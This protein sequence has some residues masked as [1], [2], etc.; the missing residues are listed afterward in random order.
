MKRKFDKYWDNHDELN[1]L[2]FIAV[3]LDPRYKVKYLDFCFS[4]IYDKEK[5]KRFTKKVEDG[6]TRLFECY[7]EA[8]LA[9]SNYEA[10]NAPLVAD[11]EEYADDPRRLW[12]SNFREHLQVIE[13]KA[14]NTE[15]SRFLSELCE[16]DT[17]EFNIL[18]WW[19]GQRNKYPTL[20]KVAKDVLAVPVSTI[21]SES[22]FST[23]GRV[24][25]PQRSSLSPKMV[26]ALICAQSWLR[27]SP[28]KIDIRQTIVDLQ[29]YEELAQ[30]KNKFLSLSYVCILDV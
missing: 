11:L 4:N 24:I 27:S 6:L 14:S 19:R 16:K 2:L 5:A 1:P 7:A 15:L 18:S 28:N 21:A 20:S 3:A 23:G 12:A 8:D 22:S 29:K 26:E 30:G 25:N 9:A 13:S 10:P 17:N